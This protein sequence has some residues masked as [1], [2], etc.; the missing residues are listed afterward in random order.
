M[1]DAH[2]NHGQTP[3]A[4]TAVG[5]MLLGC[6]IS[7]FGV[8]YL[9]WPLFW[10]GLAVVALGAVAGKVMQMLGFGRTV[11]YRQDEAERRAGEEAAAS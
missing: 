5:I 1:A 2:D 8:V 9:N 3:A 11:T 4:W 6:I 10:A 7:A